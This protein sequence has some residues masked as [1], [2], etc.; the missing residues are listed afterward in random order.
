MVL[1]KTDKVKT[2]EGSEWLQRLRSRS[3]EEFVDGYFATR[4]S[5]P[6][7]RD[8][9]WDQAR[10]DERVFFETDQWNGVPRDQLGVFKLAKYL[11]LQLGSMI[12]SK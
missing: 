10:E 3:A 2:G 12:Q 5:G 9:S 11:S 8:Q 4:L 6:D 7:Q 1:P